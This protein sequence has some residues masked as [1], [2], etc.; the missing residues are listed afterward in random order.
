[1]RC[2]NSFEYKI[3][4]APEIALDAI[5]IPGMFIQPIVEN[6]IV[7]GVNSLI[8][9]AGQIQINFT[10]KSNTILNCVI[11]DN[12]IGRK[13][14][15]ELKKNKSKYHESMGVSISQERIGY[16]NRSKET[17]TNIEIIDLYDENGNSI[18]TQV[19]I[20]LPILK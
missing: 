17:E 5:K 18:G 12:G 6:A 11:K 15:E 3:T 14:S 13:A 2:D 4:I 16:Y 8:D 19:T 20:N 10:L 1:M 9:R 7:H